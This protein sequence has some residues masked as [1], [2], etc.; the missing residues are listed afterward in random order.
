MTSSPPREDYNIQKV[1]AFLQHLAT[2]P[3]TRT[4]PPSIKGDQARSDFFG[5]PKRQVS[6]ATLSDAER[7]EA[8]PLAQTRGFDRFL[9]RP[10]FRSGASPNN[11]ET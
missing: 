3:P 8:D 7:G 4:H 9:A 1:R 5:A 10:E 6:L 2:A 11:H